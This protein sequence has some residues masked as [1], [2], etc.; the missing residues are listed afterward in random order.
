MFKG[1]FNEVS[2]MFERSF[3][4]ESSKVVQVRLKS[5]S[6]SFK[7]DSRVLERSSTG[8]SG[9]FQWCFK[10]VSKKFQ[11]SFKKVSRV[12]QRSFKG[13]PRK[14]QVCLKED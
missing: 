7:G 8:M 14:F 13:I 11:G 9:K 2:N 3:S 4:E 6:S 5:I 1:C 10:K 12:V